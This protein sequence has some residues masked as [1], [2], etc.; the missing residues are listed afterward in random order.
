VVPRENTSLFPVRQTA[1]RLDEGL[2]L[3]RQSKHADARLL[4]LLVAFG[5]ALTH[6]G[7]R[8]MSVLGHRVWRTAWL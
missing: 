6:E 8:T 7:D 3:A 2:A 1:S 5:F 4:R